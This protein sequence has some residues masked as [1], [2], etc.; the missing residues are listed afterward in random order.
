MMDTNLIIVEGLPATGKTTIAQFLQIQLE[1]NDRNVRWFHEVAHPHP[2]IFIP[3]GLAFD[4]GY[5]KLALEKWVAFTEKALRN[6]NEMHIVDS[7]VFQF[8]I[9]WF[10]LNNAPYADLENFICEI[11]KIIEPLNPCLFYLYR[12]NTEA[13]IDFL[14][15]DRGTQDLAKLW[16]RD[17]ALPYYGD[18]PKGAEGFKYF[19]RD[20][21]ATA[22][23][24][25]DAAPCR[26]AS[27]E[28]SEGWDSCKTEM[29]S[30][31]EIERTAGPGGVPINGVYQNK[32]SKMT[33][34]GLTMVDP[35]GST[36]EL[37]PKSGNEFYVERLPVVLRF[38]GTERIVIAGSQICEHWTTTGT[39]FI[40]A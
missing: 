18:K 21:A 2:T 22:K 39:I 24:L 36:R 34:D 19:L 8:P 14:E 10:S 4:E 6:S 32:E 17:R 12:G 30:F 27:L 20:Y 9:F 35:S 5:K 11:F 3:D 40:K 26:K 33:V 16:E 23:A 37:I 13:S 15:K 31:M 1:R 25:F 7:A 38:E 28:V 29:L